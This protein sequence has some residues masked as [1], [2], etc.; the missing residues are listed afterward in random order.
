MR[1]IAGPVFLAIGGLRGNVLM[2]GYRVYLIGI[3]S[4]YLAQAT[5]IGLANI[6]LQAF[7]RVD[8]LLKV[9]CDASKNLPSQVDRSGCL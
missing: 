4:A 6:G 9:M 7:T 8:M 3:N 1:A 2:P 5:Q